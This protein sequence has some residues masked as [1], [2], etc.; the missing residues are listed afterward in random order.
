MTK[1]FYEDTKQL[2]IERLSVM[3][4]NKGISIGNSGNT[5]T[6]DQLIDEVEKG[7]VIGHKIVQVELEFLQ[8]LKDF[9]NYDLQIATHN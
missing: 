8:S 2:V 6:K 7:S 4:S 9:K 1:S 3:S 5:Y